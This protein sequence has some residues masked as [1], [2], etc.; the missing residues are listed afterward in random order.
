MKTL[1]SCGLVKDADYRI[2]DKHESARS[3]SG[4]L[5]REGIHALLVFEDRRMIGIITHIDIVYA[6]RKRR[7]LDRITAEDIMSTTIVALSPNTTLDEAKPVFERTRYVIIPIFSNS[8]QLQGV[9]SVYDF[10]HLLPLSDDDK[11]NST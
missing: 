9:V 11:P 7:D 1:E 2:I 3:I 6:V 8:N 5:G 4:M 10:F